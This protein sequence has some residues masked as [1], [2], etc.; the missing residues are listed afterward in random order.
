MTICITAGALVACSS[1][2]KLA[3]ASLVI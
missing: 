3:D 1:D 2:H